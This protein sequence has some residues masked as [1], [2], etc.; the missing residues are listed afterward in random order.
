MGRVRSRRGLIEESCRITTGQLR[1][2]GY[3]REGQAK[4]TVTFTGRNWTVSIEIESVIDSSRS[5]FFF[6]YSY[7]ANGNRVAEWFRLEKVA[8]K[9]GDRFFFRCRQTGKK[10]SALYFVNG[11]FGSRYAHDLAYR[12]C[13]EHRLWLEN[14]RRFERYSAKWKHLIWDY[15]MYIRRSNLHKGLEEAYGKKAFKYGVL[16]VKDFDHRF[17]K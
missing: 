5:A 13:G 8:L 3:L 4:G 11:R 10:V 2:W 1:D 9:Y 7:E 6:L 15:P 14:Q 17:S 16:M 12:A